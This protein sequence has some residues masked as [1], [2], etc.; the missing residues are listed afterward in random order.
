[1]PASDRTPDSDPIE[2]ISTDADGT[3]G[4]PELRSATAAPDLSDRPDSDRP[5]TKDPHADVRDDVTATPGDETP[6]TKLTP[7]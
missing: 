5:G 3:P 2:G 7:S 6:G 1:M 4:D